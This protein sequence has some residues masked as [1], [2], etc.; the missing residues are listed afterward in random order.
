MYSFIPKGMC[1]TFLCLTSAH[2][3]HTGNSVKYCSKRV[4]IDTCSSVYFIKIPSEAQTS[5]CLGDWSGD[6]ELSPSEMRS[7]WRVP[8]CSLY[9]LGL[10][11]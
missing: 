3:D 5:S 9:S 2:L 6:P 4:K 7:A 8:Q 1:N 10:G 11:E